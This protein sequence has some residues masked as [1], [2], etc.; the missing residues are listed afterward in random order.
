MQAHGFVQQFDEPVLE[1]ARA[2]VVIDFVMDIPVAPD[3]YCPVFDSE[4]VA[5]RQL[6]DAAKQRRL[7]DRVLKSQVFSQRGRIALDVG[8]E[9]Q[10]RFGLGGEHEEV[11][12]DSVIERLDAEAIT[13]AEQT[14]AG[15]VP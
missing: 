15:I 1:V 13:R 9:W 12:D 2:V 5:G 6:L 3:P 10:H 7:A 8:Q 14:F 4:E 11:A